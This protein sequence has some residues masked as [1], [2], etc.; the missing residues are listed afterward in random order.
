MKRYFAL[1]L[2][3]IVTVIS[4]G[5]VRPFQM[6]DYLKDFILDKTPYEISGTVKEIVVGPRG[7]GYVILTTEATE[8]KLPGMLLNLSTLKVGTKIDIKGTRYI[9]LVPTSLETDGYKL[10]FRRNVPQ[11]VE[12]VAV[13]ATIK[14]IEITKT[15]VNIVIV[16]ES[17]KEYRLPAAVVPFWKNLKEGMKVTLNGVKR[18]VEVKES[19]TVDGKTYKLEPRA[20]LI[21]RFA[22]AKQHAPRL[23]M[24]RKIFR[25]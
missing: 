21:Q 19:I 8:V 14:S 10:M 18:T 15:A 7:S 5:S 25:R 11:G 12:T 23:M 6:Q 24:M 4:L 13:N 1:V 2:I 22:L 17:K 20:Y 3:A 16:D 9:V